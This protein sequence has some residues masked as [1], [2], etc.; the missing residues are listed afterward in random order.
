MNQHFNIRNHKGVTL[1]EMAIVIALVVII[2]SLSFNK[3]DFLVVAKQQGEI[4]KFLTTWELLFNESLARGAAYRLTL[5][6]ETQ[7]Y[8]VRREILES[9]NTSKQVD[10]LENLRTKREKERR[11]KDSENKDTYSLEEEFNKEDER[12]SLDLETLFYTSLFADPEGTLRLAQ[13]LE[14]PSLGQNTK[15]GEGIHIRDVKTEYGT[16]KD[17]KVDL[18]FSPRGTSDFAV[19]HFLIE[20]HVTTTLL[21]PWTGEAQVYEGDKDFEWTL[22]DNQKERI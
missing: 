3:V 11:S 20:D 2:A 6:L 18:H 10:Y 5:D 1:V 16:I 17:G 4:R 7:S 15:F 14:F 13:P 12:Q 8:Y 22:D 21:N 19:I 9:A